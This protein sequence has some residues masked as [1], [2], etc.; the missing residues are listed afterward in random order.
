MTLG[1]TKRERLPFYH[2]LSFRLNIS[3]SF[4]LFMFLYKIIGILRL[5]N[6]SFVK[7]NVP[8]YNYKVYCPVT[9][10]DYMHMTTR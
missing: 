7:I 8:K 6:P 5:G 4:F 9:E 1:K 10:D 3:S 2:K